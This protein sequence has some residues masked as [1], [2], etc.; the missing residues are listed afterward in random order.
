MIVAR[1]AAAIIIG[2][3][4]GSIPWGV[5][6]TRR[7]ARVDVR[8]Y[9]SGK[10]G[11][12]NVLR[13]AGLKVALLVIVLDILKGAVPVMVGGAIIGHD[14]LVVGN[15]GLGAL[16]GQCLAALA[17]IAGH[18]WPVFLRFRGGR[19]VATFFGGLIAMCPLAA[20]F[21][22]EMLILSA[23]LTRFASLGSLAGAVGTYTILVPLT[24]LN[25]FPIEYLG[26][27]LLGTVFLAFMHR[28]NIMRL[29]S[30][31]ERK[32][33]AKLKA[34]LSSSKKETD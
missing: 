3:I 20:V 26:Y 17:A 12:T 8:E 9:G 32:L 29:L 31:T 7:F 11:G 2:Y 28:D 27:A 34:A 19:G 30:G 16:L 23:G 4:S 33:G 5:L 10:M 24:I 18:V 14:Y 15:I 13:V 1:F 25:G 21:G 22:G 6:L